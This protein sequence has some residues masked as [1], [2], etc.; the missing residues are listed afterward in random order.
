MKDTKIDVSLESSSGH[1]TFTASA[2]RHALA[3]VRETLGPDAIIL[4]Q[5]RIGERIVVTACPESEFDAVK[6]ALLA[7]RPNA[8]DSPADL[9]LPVIREAQEAAPEPELERP[10]EPGPIEDELPLAANHERN[11][12]ADRTARGYGYVAATRIGV[13]QDIDGFRRHLVAGLRFETPAIEDMGFAWRVLGPSGA[14]KTTFLMQLLLARVRACGTSS[15]EVVTSRAPTLAANEALQLCCEALGVR[16]TETDVR[17]LPEHLSRSSEQRLLLID[18]HG[19]EDMLFGVHD[20]LVVSAQLGPAALRYALNAP[21]ADYVV[22][23]SHLDQAI[24]ADIVLSALVDWQA[25]PAWLM[26]CSGLDQPLQG[27]DPDGLMRQL[28]G[29]PGSVGS[30]TDGAKAFRARA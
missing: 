24:D 27:A 26:A 10:P 20:L 6:A 28:F 14:G 22:V 19:D 13:E 17:Q 8:D 4:G 7:Q 30:Q 21:H 16:F 12:I 11:V 15:V 25:R 29:T 23:L 2:L 3:S 9:D 5:K 18:T 1:Y